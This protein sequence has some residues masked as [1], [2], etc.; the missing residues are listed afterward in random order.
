M[1]TSFHVRCPHCAVLVRHEARHVGLTVRCP[2]CRAFFQ[3]PPGKSD[4]FH[5]LHEWL[6]SVDHAPVESFNLENVS[7]SP[8]D[9]TFSGLE[10]PL[11]IHGRGGKTLS[12]DGS[13]IRIEKK[14]I[15][16][17]RREKTIPIGSISSVEVKEPGSVFVGFI[18]FSISGAKARDSSYTL[19]GGA[20]DAV[21]DENS[22]VFADRNA[23]ATALAVKAYVESWAADSHRGTISPTMNQSSVVDELR[24][25]K[26]LLDDG[27]LN[28]REFEQQKNRLL[29]NGR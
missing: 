7:R 20:F 1:T 16:T 24:K 3:I 27:V 17:A 26:A 11:V 12:V 28:M 19:S 2:G 15:F 13:V 9:R 23:Y 8:T 21:Q 29:Q 5:E 4:D 25:L 14:G 10:R 18:Q 6:G 22:V